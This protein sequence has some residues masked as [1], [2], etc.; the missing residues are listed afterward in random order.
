MFY[1]KYLQISALFIAM[2]ILSLA[3]S[4]KLSLY[5]HPRY[6]FFSTAMGI[7]SLIFICISWREKKAKNYYYQKVSKVGV[8]VSCLLLIMLYAPP[9]SLSQKT[10]QNRLQQNPNVAVQSK[11]SY[12]A[13]SQDFTY[14]DLQDLYSYLASQPAADRIIGKRAHVNGF[15]FDNNGT[16]YLARFQLSCCAVDATPLS[17]A[18]ENDDIAQSLRPGDWYEITGSFMQKSQKYTLKITTA[19]SIPEPKDPYVF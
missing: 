19:E 15:I 4:G 17:L 18:L 11:L 6:I 10:A 2:S 8:A 16:R 7:M 12:D 9:Q 1:K 5:I 3:K 13:F 14:F